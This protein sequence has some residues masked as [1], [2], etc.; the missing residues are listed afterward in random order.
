VVDALKRSGHWQEGA[1]P[2]P[3]SNTAAA[4]TANAKQP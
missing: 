4:A 1:K 2:G 3:T